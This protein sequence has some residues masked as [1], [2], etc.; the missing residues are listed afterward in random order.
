M[1]KRVRDP[2]KVQLQGQ[3]YYAK[4]PARRLRSR[5]R[6]KRWYYEHKAQALA[7]SKRRREARS[8][9]DYDRDKN[10]SRLYGLSAAQYDRMFLEQNGRCYIC[11]QEETRTHGGK[12]SRLAVDHNH[13][14]GQVRRLL[15]CGCNTLLGG[16]RE[17]PMTLEKAAAYLRQFQ[18]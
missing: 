16:A 18:V 3:R 6:A 1:P 7:G 14:T 15:C 5:E 4:D 13:E 2:E 11:G 10:L 12:P 8:N 9:T 17:N